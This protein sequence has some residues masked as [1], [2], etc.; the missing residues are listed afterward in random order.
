MS[1]TVASVVSRLGDLVKAIT[2]LF[3]VDSIDALIELIQK[4]GIT[5]AVKSG[6]AGLSSAVTSA[7]GWLEGLK[8]PLDQSRALAGVIGLLQPLVRGVG[9]LA[10]AS[11]EELRELGV[12]EL[13]QAI[14][15]AKRVVHIGDRLLG[16][17]RELIA[18]LPS[19][20]QITTLQEQLAALVRSLGA[21]HQRLGAPAV[22]PASG[23]AGALSGAKGGATPALPGGVL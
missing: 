6:V 23:P 18:G 20:A 19:A 11:L 1:V 14:G 15:P 7:R 4:L 5:G 17:S 9:Q 21:F 22:K 12:G 10:T 3:E 13:A 8:E 16:A 2:A